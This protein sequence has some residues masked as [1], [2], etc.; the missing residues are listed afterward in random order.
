MS[1]LRCQARCDL[2]EGH[3]GKHWHADDRPPRVW[4]PADRHESYLPGTID[5]VRVLRAAVRKAAVALTGEMDGDAV[6]RV[7]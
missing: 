3:T 6:E 4:K 5:D 1:A 7:L 2:S